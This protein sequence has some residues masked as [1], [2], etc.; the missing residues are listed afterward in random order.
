MTSSA[1]LLRL[2]FGYETPVA[3]TQIAAAP[4]KGQRGMFG[5]EASIQCL[6]DGARILRGLS[7]PN[8]WKLRGAIRRLY[9]HGLQVALLLGGAPLAQL[10]QVNH[11]RLLHLRGRHSYD[12]I[13]RF[14]RA[15]L[16]SGVR[17]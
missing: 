8:K 4:I 13:E 9:S 2:T 14:K 7:K 16:A 12:S 10:C 3:Q 11:S 15:D 17:T 6:G 1:K 5:H